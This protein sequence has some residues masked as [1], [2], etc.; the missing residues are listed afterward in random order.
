[1]KTIIFSLIF[2]VMSL[3]GAEFSYYKISKSTYTRILETETTEHVYEDESR[4]ITITVVYVR[5]EILTIICGSYLL[6]DNLYQYV[7]GKSIYIIM[8]DANGQADEAFHI[9][10]EYLIEDP[11]TILSKYL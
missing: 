7:V 2:L 3:Q 8:E 4:I 11:I 6:D 1:M 9:K 10:E 5:Q